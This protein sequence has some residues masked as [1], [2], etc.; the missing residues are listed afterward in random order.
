M[1]EFFQLEKQESPF[2]LKMQLFMML[3]CI[4]TIFV[5]AGGGSGTVSLHVLSYETAWWL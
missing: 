1:L 2:P 4:L 3:H 5:T